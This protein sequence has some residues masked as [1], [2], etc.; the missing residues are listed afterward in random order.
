[1]AMLTCANG[2]SIISETIFENRFKHVDGLLKMGADVKIDGRTAVIRGVPA[3][4]GADVR[5]TDL[6][7]GAALLVAALGAKGVSRIG[8]IY[9]IDRGYESI[10]TMFTNLGAQVAREK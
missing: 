4:S 3:L 10:E 7:G 1:M 6:R 9:H 2:S 8:D 5:A